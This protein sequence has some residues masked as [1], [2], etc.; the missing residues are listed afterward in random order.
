[1]TLKSYIL[2]R[3]ERRGEGIIARFGKHRC[4]WEL[5]WQ[6][7][8]A[9]SEPTVGRARMEPSSH[10]GT[11]KAQES[12]APGTSGRRDKVGTCLRRTRRS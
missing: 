1:M 11:P 7:S 10:C 5:T 9:G 3:T 12:V 8:K 4:E 6:P 2:T